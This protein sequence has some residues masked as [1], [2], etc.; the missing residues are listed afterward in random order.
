METR[1]NPAAIEAKWQRF[2]EEQDLFRVTEEPWQAQILCPGNVPLSLGADSHGPCAQLHHRRRGGPVQAH[3]GLQRPAPHGLGRLRHAR[4]KCRHGP[5]HSIRPPGPT[6][7]STTCGSS[8]NPWATAMTGAGKWPPAIPD[9]Y[10]WE[11]LVFI[12]MFERGLAYK[13]KSPVNWCDHCQTVLANEQVEDGACWRCDQPVVLRELEQWFFKIT[14]YVEELLEYCDQPAR[15]AGTGPDHAAQLDRQVR[16]GA[17]PFPGGR[18]GGTDR[19]LHHQ[20][21][22]PVRR[23]VHEPGPGAPPGPGTGPGHPQEAGGPGFHAHL[24]AAGPEQGGW[25]KNW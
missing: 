20:A 8:S 21:G 13:K 12:E 10:R 22:H 4:G 16:G 3:A 6:K 11:Q 17:D 15:L 7:T 23:H 2:W 25:W 1:Y 24:E 9:Y 19:G 14:D 5:R 18:P